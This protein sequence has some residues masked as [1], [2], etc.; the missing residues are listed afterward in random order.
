[1]LASYNSIHVTWHDNGNGVF[2]LYRQ[3]YIDKVKVILNDQNKHKPIELNETKLIVKLEDQAYRARKTLKGNG[4]INDSFHH[5]AFSS[6]LQIGSLFG[7]PKVHK[8]G[9]PVPPILVA[10]SKPNFN[11]GKFP[12][13]YFI[14]I[15]SVILRGKIL[16]IMFRVLVD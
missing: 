11:F 12:I 7:Q 14:E 16:T 2:I 6:G 10:P 9:W 15:V 8:A 13:P 4:T 3:I 1:M 5:A